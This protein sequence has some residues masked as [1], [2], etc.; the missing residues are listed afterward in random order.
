MAKS[1]AFSITP[2]QPA[3]IWQIGGHH[4]IQRIK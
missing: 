1:E 3:V 2:Q 4:S